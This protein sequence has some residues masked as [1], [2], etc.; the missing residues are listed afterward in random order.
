MDQRSK[1]TSH[2][3]RDSDTLQHG[4]IRSNRGSRH[5]IEFFNQFAIIN[6]KAASR[7]E[8]D[9]PASSSSSSTSPTTTVLSDSAT[10]TREDLSGIDSHPVPVSSSH[11][12]RIERG[13]PLWSKPTTNPKPKKNENHDIERGDPLYS[14]FSGMAARIQRKSR[15]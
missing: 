1:T 9:H 3:K 4:K 10:R 2:K 5:V 8:N 15:G 7:H 13:D 12:E 6:N 11:V 14:D